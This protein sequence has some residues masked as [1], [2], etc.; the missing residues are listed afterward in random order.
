MKIIQLDS[1]LLQILI[2]ANDREFNKLE[3]FAELLDVSTRSIRNYIKQLNSTLPKEIAQLIS[4]K[5][6]GYKLQVNSQQKFEE[7]INYYLSNQSKIYFL[8]N[9]EERSKYIIKK[10]ID[11][12]YPIKIDELAEEISVGRTTL[13]N[14]LKKIAKM[15]NIYEL[16]IKGKQGEGI[17]LQGNELNIRLFVLDFLS[18]GFNNED[19][20]GYYFGDI[21]GTRR[22]HIKK[23][24]IGLFNR[25]SFFVTNETIEEILSYITVLLVRVK[26]NRQIK[27]IDR[28]YEET[29]T[30]EECTLAKRIKEEVENYFDLSI[31][32]NET[33]FLTLPLLL[34]KAPIDNANTGD[35]RVSTTVKLLVERILEEVRSKMGIDIKYDKEFVCN[36]ECHLNFALNRL[37]FNMKINNPLLKEIKK[38]YPLPYEMAKIGAKVIEQDYGVTINGDEIGYM[39]LHFGSFIERNSERF[40][41]MEKVALVCGTGLGTAK[42]LYIKLKKL[43]GEDKTIRTFSDVELTKDLLDEYDIVFTT[44][45]INIC[46]T[47]PIIKVNAIFD[48]SEVQREIEKRYYLKKYNLE[49]PQSDLALFNIN[50][51]EEQFFI[52]EEESFIDNLSYMIDKLISSGYVDEGFKQRIIEREFKSPTSF[53]NY[54]AL[55]HA[56]NYQ[57][58]R[59][60]MAIGILEKPIFWGG[61]ET[62]IIILLMIPN[63]EYVDPELLIKTY[64]ELLKLCQDK[65]LVESMSKARSY[66]EFSNLLQRR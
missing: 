52:L 29:L 16:D 15:L 50:I 47:T 2:R 5:E 41:G 46:T 10:L 30:T 34:R 61:N 45:D 64:E 12:Q 37:I 25:E 32:D 6:A 55:P 13:V 33:I 51:G 39:A 27:S 31:G 7:L 62:R 65:K 63:N 43:L 11:A 59:I 18:K 58:D 66:D 23:Y 22:E 38:C 53:D 4:V 3:D 48:E 56:V 9:P 42:L 44:V 14:D 35:I 17:E 40:F 60:S 49:S 57:N 36:L 54:I 19:I 20:I 21:D 24:L 26:N 8:N 28:K 1:R